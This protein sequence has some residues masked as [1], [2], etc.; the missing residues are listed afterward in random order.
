MGPL[1]RGT[2]TE[3]PAGFDEALPPPIEPIAR[4]ASKR[5]ARWLGVL[6]GAVAGLV[7]VIAVSGAGPALSA[8]HRG[9]VLGAFA[10]VLL[11]PVIAISSFL[12]MLFL[13]FSLEGVLGDSMWNRLS[14]ALM[15][16]RLRPLLLP[17]CV[18]VLLPMALCAWGASKMPNNAALAIPA[19]LGAMAL[20]A[21]V[22][23]ICGSL[24]GSAQQRGGHPGT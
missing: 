9:A 14:D 1:E 20:G 17:V 6:L 16:R 24:I 4:A 2:R 21:F 23:A 3:R 13:P 12:S 8:A 19:A 22:G 5:A 10:G 11:A 15:Y 7:A 18:F